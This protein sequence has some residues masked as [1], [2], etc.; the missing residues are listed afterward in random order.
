MAI[1][2]T[3]Q[4]CQC[5][6]SDFSIIY[7]TICAKLKQSVQV[8]ALARIHKVSCAVCHGSCHLGCIEGLQGELNAGDVVEERP[9]IPVSYDNLIDGSQ[10]ATVG[11]LRQG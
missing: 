11:Y 5:F 3:K 1:V 2:N 4:V 7:L 10:V 8:W 6:N 9:I